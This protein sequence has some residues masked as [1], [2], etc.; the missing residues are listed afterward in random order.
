[1]KTFRF[2]GM[3]LFAVLLCVN[4]AA[5]SDSDDPTEEKEEENT[6]KTKKIVEVNCDDYDIYRFTYDN[7]GRLSSCTSTHG[8]NKKII[9]YSWSENS[10][11]ET[12][13]WEGEENEKHTRNYTLKNGLVTICGDDEQYS[14][15]E[16]KQLIYSN[17]ADEDYE[18]I[19]N[20]NKLVEAYNRGRK[21]VF[22]Y[23]DSDVCSG[24]NI[25]FLSNWFN[26]PIHMA[27]PELFGIKTTELPYKREKDDNNYSYAYTLDE[28]GYIIKTKTRT[29]TYESNATFKWE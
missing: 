15:N 6:K 8:R 13:W 22:K 2:I 3:A 23:G 16:S 29:D 24:Y 20:D 25:N 26:R 18:L 21:N 7:K 1:M 28:E 19:W 5:C 4:F 17:F 10:I 12:R 11:Q 14:Y 27:H 9:E